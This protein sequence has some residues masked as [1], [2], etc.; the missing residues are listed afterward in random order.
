MG[1]EDLRRSG[2]ESIGDVP[3]GTHLCQFYETRDDLKSTLVPYFKE[4]LAANEFCMWVTSHPLSV[5]EALAALRSVV[6]DLDARVARGQI[7]VLD[8]SQWY[9]KDGGFKEE[10]V[11][12]GWMDRLAAARE[13]G[14]EGLRLT[15]NTFWLEK[16]DWA[17]FAHY[18]ATIN[19]VI[20]AQRML[21]I[22]TYS[23]E[24]C[25]ALEIA[26]VIANHEFALLK[27]AGRWEVIGSMRHRKTAD[28]LREREEDYRSLFES[29][30]EG[31]AVHEMI[32]DPEGA[33][34]DYRFLAVNPAFERL[35]GLK[36]DDIVG[37]TALEV[38][39]GLEPGWVETYGRVV[40]TGNPVRFTSYTAPLRRHF[41]VFSFRPAA[42]RFA[43]VFSDVT[44]RNTIEWE[45]E[46]MVA[47]L[48]M[49]NE[50]RSVDGFARGAL[51]FV[52]Q[53]FG[54]DAVAIRLKVGGDCPYLAADGFTEDFV[55]AESSF[56]PPEGGGEPVFECLCGNVICGRFDASSS[57]STSQGSFWTN[58]TTELIAGSP[59]AALLTKPRGRCIKEGYESVG[60]FALR[61][62][63]ER[64]GLLQVNDRRRGVLSSETVALLERLADVMTAA[65]LRLQAAEDLSRSED[66]LRKHRDDLESVVRERT[67]ELTERTEQLAQAQR[68]AHMGSWTLDLVT[69]HLAWSDE[70]YRIFELDP[71]T[72]GASYEA[73]LDAIHPEDRGAVDR[74]Y[75][76]SLQTRKSYTI[77]H[78]LLM[79]DG[80]VKYVVERCE[81]TFDESGRPLRSMGTVQDVTGQRQAERE[82]ER[83]Q[84]ELQQ[85]QKMEAIGR[86]AG[87]VAHDFNNMLAVI[88]GF[89]DTTLEDMKRTNPL[90]G[91]L[92]EVRAAAGR[93]AELTS[94][95]LTFSRRQ[96]TDPRA[97]DLNVVIKGIERMLKRTIGEDVLLKI[98]LARGVGTVRAD[99]RQIGQV[100][101]NLAIN[102][103]DAMPDGGRLT[104][105]TSNVE[106]D[107]GYL[108]THPAASEGPHVMLAV[109][110]T[111]RGMDADAKARVFEPFYTTK[112]NGTGLGLSIVYGIVK[113]AGGNV[114]VYSEPGHGT[115]FKIYLPRVPAPAVTPSTGG[116]LDTTRGSGT[117]LIVEDEPAM[118]K[119]TS[120]VLRRSGYTVLVAPDGPKALELVRRHRGKIRLMVTDVVMPGMGGRELAERV[121]QLDSAIG[122]L[123]TSG[124]TT[125]AIVHHG[126]LDSGTQFIQKPFAPRA[127]LRKVQ[128]VLRARPKR[129]LSAGI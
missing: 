41:E 122:V 32:F 79:K 50:A 118:R 46:T 102:A 69:N 77:E 73:F 75:T 44:A 12:K 71:A 95:L 43:A 107:A 86:L 125:S 82:R 13:R 96:I 127:F 84:G 120:T 29:M 116:K 3:W 64:L 4:G 19:D 62:G 98:H 129:G 7:E 1:R 85:S 18:E 114:V 54:F 58:S 80:R 33:P 8:Y 21:A 70:I 83:L 113:Q 60:L 61:S 38:L 74:A 108:R 97:V 52:R 53:R 24:K 22:C 56:S 42:G 5:D 10:T 57:F 110:D 66:M 14:F 6:P 45:R 100:I 39:P 25:G 35:T 31:F 36:R 76:G 68:I 115:S 26:E 40:R 17:G 121:A 104:I 49:A 23:L 119:M 51:G 55:R 99:A 65:L 2:I 126:V 87:G 28:A 63:E 111:G 16:A 47:F 9:T 78:R 93:A 106:L 27:R 112:E 117:I 92:R 101:M 105:E 67:R 103:R 81:T 20:G 90:R 91:N 128:E 124:Y 123:Y 30:S 59:E 34:R 89:T 88:I 109:S 11:L 37:R 48:R 15:G 72:F 94:D